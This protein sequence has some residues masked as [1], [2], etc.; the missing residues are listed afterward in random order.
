MGAAWDDPFNGP[1]LGFLSDRSGFR[2]F[3]LAG[4]ET[5]PF[6]VNN[7]GMH[8]GAFFDPFFGAQVYVTIHGYPYTVYEISGLN[9]KGQMGQHF[10]F[11]QFYV[12]TL[13]K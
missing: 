4:A 13:P 8:A 12:S 9:D 3:D 6:T 11:G 7:L 1:I 5:Y 2:R 10:G